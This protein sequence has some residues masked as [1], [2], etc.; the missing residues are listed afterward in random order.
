MPEYNLGEVLAVLHLF[1]II[2]VLDCVTTPPDCLFDK[3]IMIKASLWAK[4]DPKWVQNGQ[5]WSQNPGIT[6]F[7]RDV[8]IETLKP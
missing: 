4:H 3:Q 8:A 1:T 6:Q 5:K 2:L 7:P